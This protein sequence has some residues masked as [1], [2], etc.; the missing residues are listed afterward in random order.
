VNFTQDTFQVIAGKTVHF[1]GEVSYR[2]GTGVRMDVT[3]PERQILILRGSTVLIVLP[4]QGTSQVQDVPPE[5]AAQNILGFFTG[6]SSIESSYS[7]QA[8][9]DH[10]VLEPRKGTG[11]ISVWADRD[12]LIRR[13]LLKDA[14]GNTS[15]VRLSGYRFN[16][17]LPASLFSTT[18]QRAGAR[19]GERS[20]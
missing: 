16:R 10:L 8:V 12:H 5:I 18:A 9:D 14:M 11:T 15:D 3:V 19:N 17:G 13:I 2:K 20:P 6:L 1:E 7:V 4:E